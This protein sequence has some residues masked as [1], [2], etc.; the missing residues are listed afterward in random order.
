MTNDNYKKNKRK[1]LLVDDEPDI[2]YSIKRLLEDNEFVVDT[3]TDPTL[4]LSNFK[5]RL[6]D[7]LLLDI[8]MPK[9]SGLDL[10]QKMKE[11]DSNVKICF[12]TASE[13]FYEEYRRL[14]AYPSLDKA[15]F[16]QKPFR[17]EELI[18]KINEIMHSN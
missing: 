16:V 5:P 17:S 14:D 15:Y 2:I 8:K 4:A 9:M 7:L 6:Y 12:L 10:Y 18:R 13:L 11:I 3:Y 1:I